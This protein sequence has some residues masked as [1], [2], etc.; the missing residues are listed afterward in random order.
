MAFIS[1]YRLIG[2]VFVKQAYN[3][4]IWLFYSNSEALIPWKSKTTHSVFF[5]FSA[6]GPLFCWELQERLAFKQKIKLLYKAASG[7]L[8]ENKRCGTQIFYGV[9]T[10]NRSD[11][12]T[13]FG[14]YAKLHSSSWKPESLHFDFARSYVFIFSCVLVVGLYR[15]DSLVKVSQHNWIFPYWFLSASCVSTMLPSAVSVRATHL[16]TVNSTKGSYIKMKVPFS[17]MSRNLLCT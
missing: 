1:K 14:K 7:I 5:G 13:T 11:V 2:F 17:R 15:Y 9:F 12:L 6:C 3:K 16:P 10:S 8:E 4:L